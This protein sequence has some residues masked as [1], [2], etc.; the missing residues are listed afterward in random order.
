M[1]NLDFNC[2]DEDIDE[3]YGI[4]SSE[5]NRPDYIIYGRKENRQ[6]WEFTEKEGASFEY[7]EKI[8]YLGCA[9][10]KHIA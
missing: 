5:N 3:E 1:L 10:N 4:W 7:E 6:R 9:G 2:K 8:N